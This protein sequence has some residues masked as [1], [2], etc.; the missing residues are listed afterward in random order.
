MFKVESNFIG[1]FNLGDRIN[2]ELKILDIIY[3]FNNSNS[4]ISLNKIKVVVIASVC[5]AVLYDFINTRIKLHTREGVRNIEVE[6]LEKIKDKEYKKFHHYIDASKKYNFFKESKGLCKD[7]KSLKELRNCIHIQN[8]CA[9]ISGKKL[10]EVEKTLEIL[11]KTMNEK[12][13]RPVSTTGWVK[14]FEIPF[15]EKL[16]KDKP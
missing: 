6:H 11:L 8:K 13:H 7:L 1:D 5:E 2:N 12:Y 10:L 16:P 14:D 9:E 4:S 3:K 15:D